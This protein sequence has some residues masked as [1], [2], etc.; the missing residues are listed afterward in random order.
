MREKGDVMHIKYI[1]IATALIMLLALGIFGCN[2]SGSIG[3]VELTS[4]GEGTVEGGGGTVDDG[5]GDTGGSGGTDDTGSGSADGGDEALPASS[6]IYGG[7]LA[8]GDAIRLEV[9]VPSFGRIASY[10]ITTDEESIVSYTN[11][12]EYYVYELATEVYGRGWIQPGGYAAF[13]TPSTMDYELAMA[14]A[15]DP[16]ITELSSFY[17]K[18]YIG[19][20]FRHDPNGAQF[21]RMDIGANGSISVS[22]S[23]NI[24]LA[25]QAQD[26][27][28]LSFEDFTYYPGLNCFIVGEDIVEKPITLFARDGAMLMDMGE[29]EGFTILIEQPESTI[30]DGVA[31]G[32]AFRGF[33]YK[34]EAEVDGAVNFESTFAVTEIPTNDNIVFTL[35]NPLEGSG[36]VSLV[37]IGAHWPGF[38]GLEDGSVGLIFL[39]ADAIIFADNH[40]MPWGFNYGI[41]FKE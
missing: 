36:S 32:D 3:L 31:V 35:T 20:Q 4:G 27:P 38:F 19:I 9:D 14:M 1:G 40:G 37:P 21:I 10:N 23:E 34:R 28:G 15:V 26:D 13:M 16:A 7:A 41:A 17:G 5:D 6:Y 29:G 12:N 25:P 11:L 30:P 18:S 2:R 24:N 33:E 22:L 8:K 39:G